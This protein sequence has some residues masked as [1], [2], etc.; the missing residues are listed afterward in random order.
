MD[1]LSSSTVHLRPSMENNH[2]LS[3]VSVHEMEV[4]SARP[5][6]SI[7]ISFGI[8]DGGFTELYTLPW[9]PKSVHLKM[10]ILVYRLISSSYRPPVEQICDAIPIRETE[11]ELLLFDKW[12]TNR[13]H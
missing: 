5:Y 8:A 6:T 11:N 1:G 2:G 13:H 7:G 4:P 9:S 10:L 3:S 12:G